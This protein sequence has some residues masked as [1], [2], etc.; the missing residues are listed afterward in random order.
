MIERLDTKIIKNI[1]LIW[2]GIIAFYGVSR[3][4]QL[5]WNSSSSM[6]QQLWLTVVGNKDLKLGDYVV[7]KFHDFR[8]S[9]PDDFE[10]VV[11][12]VGGVAGDQIIVQPLLLSATW[13][14]ASIGSRTPTTQLCIYQVA[15]ASYPVYANLSGNHFTPLTT[16]NMTIPEGCYFVH[17]QHQPSFDS[18]YKEFGLVCE[19][20]IYGKSYPLF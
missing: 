12:Q 13:P 5:K 14:K 10:Y 1:L 9:D 6:P 2:A 18:R 16:K 7:F 3:F 11:K 17:G 20:Q 8:M 15:Q 4:Y 19:S